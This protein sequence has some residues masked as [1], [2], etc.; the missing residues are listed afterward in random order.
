M[1][2]KTL[3]TV[4]EK[5]YPF[6]ILPNGT[7]ILIEEAPTPFER[8]TVDHDFLFEIDEPYP[9]AEADEAQD[10]ADGLLTDDD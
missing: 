1:K 6:E 8:S 4:D 5:Q 10:R 3:V 2:P 7:I 9:N